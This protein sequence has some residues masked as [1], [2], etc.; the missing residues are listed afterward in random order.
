MKR[1][2]WVP[3]YA[4]AFANWYYQ[5]SMRGDFDQTLA[6]ELG[7][8]RGWMA[9]PACDVEEQHKYLVSNLRTGFAL[10]EFRE[11]FGQDVRDVV[12][13]AL[14]RL[15]DL[16][17]IDIDDEQLVSRTGTHARNLV[18]RV[19]LYSPMMMERV[20]RVWGPEYDRGED[21]EGR[22]RILVGAHD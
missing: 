16:D 6:R 5:P 10:E 20:D 1:T 2:S 12:P 14:E 7:G 3:S 8:E 18:H 11:I 13:D 15:V 4:H 22:L 21:Y 17:V 19:L 9:V